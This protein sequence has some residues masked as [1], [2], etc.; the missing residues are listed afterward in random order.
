MVEVTVRVM[1]IVALLMPL[2]LIGAQLVGLARSPVE[3]LVVASTQLIK[4]K[5]GLGP[6]SPTQEEARKR[7]W[8]SKRSTNFILDYTKDAINVQFDI[9]DKLDTKLYNVFAAATVAIGLASRLPADDANRMDVLSLVGIGT[10]DL[11]YLAVVA[12]ALTLIAA[13]LHLLTKR[14]RASL[15]ADQLWEK[16][17]SRRRRHLKLLLVED[18][19]AAYA[20]NLTVL[21]RKAKTVNCAVWATG[22]E[23]LYIVIALIFSR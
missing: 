6:N 8:A 4:R 14:H 18:I 12:Y 15:Q 16:H 11:F 9:S 5:L 2:V 21:G 10:V 17:R 3:S 1:L 23:G 20:H 7:D 19:S 13:I 22:F